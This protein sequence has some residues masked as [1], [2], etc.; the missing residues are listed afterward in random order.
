M[1]TDTSDSDSSILYKSYF[2]SIDEVVEHITAADTLGLGFRVES[3][4]VSTAEEPN[5]T[6]PQ[7]EFTLLADSPVHAEGDE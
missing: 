2:S 1:G 7:F 6:H 5:G 3:Y 4:V